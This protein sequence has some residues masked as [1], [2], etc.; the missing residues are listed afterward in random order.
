MVTWE[1]ITDWLIHYWWTWTILI[2]I[3]AFWIYSS[4]L[5]PYQRYSLSKIFTKGRLLII[6]MLLG[7]FIWVKVGGSSTVKDAHRWMPIIVLL[8]IAGSNYVGKLKYDSKQAQFIN[9]HASFTRVW[10]MDGFLIINGGAFNA[11]GIAWDY[12][13]EV[14]VIRK[15]T[16][17]F[18]EEGGMSIASVS[19][20][21]KYDIPDS[22][23]K[24]CEKNTFLKGAVK[25]QK[26]YYGWFDDVEQVDYDLKQ[27]KDFDDAKAKHLYG[28]LKKELGVE[29]PKVETLLWLYKNQCKATGK[30]TEVLD[31]AVETA[32]K[33][34][35]HH[36]RM[37]D[38]YVGKEE[39]YKHEGAEEQY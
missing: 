25:N 34:A 29:N 6:G 1:Q 30:Q 9:K 3:I 14:Y 22:I 36:K 31:S 20:A 5:S 27:L 7:W 39:N 13:N 15:E 8:V 12:A 4:K 26:I 19:P 2:I 33:G 28:L 32:E 24:F 37:K 23:W 38:T 35:E 17:E 18:L 11:G 16:W 10:E 21:S